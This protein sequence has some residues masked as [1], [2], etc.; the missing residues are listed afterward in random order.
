MSPGPSGPKMRRAAARVT[1]DPAVVRFI[2]ALV[3]RT[4][5]YPGLFLGASPRA[6]IAMLTGGRALAISRGRA[7]VVPDDIVD[8]ALPA[9]RH[10]VIVSPEAEV[11]GRTADAILGELI[12]SVEVPRG[13]G[14]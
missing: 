6:G 13:I 4:R 11:E 2:G 14:K 10:R 3:R 9:L 5:G 7:F 1:V 12:R 8:V